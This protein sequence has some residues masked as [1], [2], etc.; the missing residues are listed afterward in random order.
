MKAGDVMCLCAN[1]LLQ[2][3]RKEEEEEEEGEEGERERKGK[4]GKGHKKRRS[5]KHGGLDEEEK[6]KRG[7]CG[8]NTTQCL[9]CILILYVTL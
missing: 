9:H 2:K 6:S 5:K 7:C 3:G 4:R 8:L 1:G